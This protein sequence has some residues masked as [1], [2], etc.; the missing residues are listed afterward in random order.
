MP[1]QCMQLTFLKLSEFTRCSH[2]VV[3]ALH[4]GAAELERAGNHIAQDG[5]P[6]GI[7]QLKQ[8]SS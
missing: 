4:V 6:A 1:L 5:R 3:Q 8:L 7:V 2:N